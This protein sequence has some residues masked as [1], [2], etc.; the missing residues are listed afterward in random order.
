MRVQLRAYVLPSALV[1][2]RANGIGLRVRIPP[3][4]RSTLKYK[5]EGLRQNG[6]ENPGNSALENPGK[7]ARSD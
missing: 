7:Q 5:R 1:I 6:L 4:S 3:G 2:A